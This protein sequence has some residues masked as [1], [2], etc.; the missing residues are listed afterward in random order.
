MDPNA[1]H[2]AGD[3]RRQRSRPDPRAGADERVAAPHVRALR[4]DVLSRLRR[5]AELDAS[6]IDLARVLDHYDRVGPRRNRRPGVDLRAGPR[7]DA[8]QPLGPSPHELEP[9][10]RRGP[11]G[12]I[13]RPHRVAVHHRAVEGREVVRGESVLCQ[14]VA[15]RVPD[16]GFVVSGRLHMPRQRVPDRLD[17]RRVERL[18]CHGPNCR[19]RRAERQA[20]AVCDR[21]AQ[22]R[23]AQR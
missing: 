19:A 21:P 6:V 10:Q 3:Q 2:A 16:G 22:P 14:H 15:E 11:V 8:R 5:V 7:L 4:I 20:N 1:H 23:F 17:A 13:T 18:E 12:E 9:A